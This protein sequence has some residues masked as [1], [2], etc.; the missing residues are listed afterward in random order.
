MKSSVKLPQSLSRTSK[1]DKAREICKVHYWSNACK[2]VIQF[3]N[4]MGIEIDNIGYVELCMEDKLDVDIYHLMKTYKIMEVINSSDQ[5]LSIIFCKSKCI[6]CRNKIKC[7]LLQK[8]DGI[9]EKL[10][11]IE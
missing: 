7:E 11:Q 4:L 6:E 1:R 8:G 9:W 5:I 10:I 2:K 3:S